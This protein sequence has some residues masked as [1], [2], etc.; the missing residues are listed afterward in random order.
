MGTKLRRVVITGIGIVSPF[1]VG[2][3]VLFENLVANNYALQFDSKLKAVL[4][5]VPETE[6]E[7]SLNL[8]EW[9]AAGQMR[10][11]SR[12]FLIFFLAYELQIYSL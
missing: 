4:G 6:S 12:G 8:S 10:R 7:S 9:K 5:R 11:V 3:K 1:G 2:K